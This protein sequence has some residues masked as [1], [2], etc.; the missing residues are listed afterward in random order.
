[1]K[2][3]ILST[4]TTLLLSSF[5]MMAFAQSTFTVSLLDSEGIATLNYSEAKVTFWDSG[6]KTAINNND[7]TFTVNTSSS[8]ETV[9]MIYYG[10]STSANISADYTFNTV[11][12]TFELKGCDDTPLEGGDIIVWSNGYKTLGSTDASGLYSTE[13]LPVSDQF[14]MQYDGQ[15]VEKTQDVGANPTVTFIATK[16][17][18]NWSGGIRYWS[19]G[20]QWFNSPQYMLKDRSFTFFEG[21]PPSP[22]SQVLTTTVPISGCTAGGTLIQLVDETDAPL[23]NFGGAP[24]PNNLKYR[25]RCGGSWANSGTFETDANG[26]AFLTTSCA[27]NNWDGKITVTV[28]QT[29]KEQDVTVNS[30]FQLSKVNVTLN[31]CDPSTPI[32]GG[33][34]DQGGGYWYNHGTTDASGTVS[35]YAFAGNNVKVRMGYNYNSSETRTGVPVEFP[36]TNIDYTTTTLNIRSGGEV[37]IA[38][39]SWFTVTS[40]SEILPGTYDFTFDGGPKTPIEVSGCTFEKTAVTVKLIDSD[41]NGLEGGEAKYNSGGWQSLGTT[42]E[43]GEIF[44]LLDDP[45]KTYAFRMYWEGSYV[46]K[47]QNL[48]TNSVVVFQTV[49][50]QMELHASDGT[51]QLIGEGKVNSGGWKTLGNT[52]TAGKELL[53]KTYAFR[54][55]YEGSYIQK[56]QNIGADPLVVFETVL[57]KMELHASDGTTQLT[58]EG[59]V[60][61]GGWKSMGNTPDAEKELL[62][63]TYAFRIYYEG[64]YIQKNQDIGSDPLVVFETVLATV[65]LLDS[66]DSEL[67]AEAKV[68]SDGW[69]TMGT[70][71][72][73]MELLPKTYAFRVYFEGTYLQKNQNIATDPVVIFRGTSVTLQFT[74]DIQYNSGGWKTFSS[75]MTLLPK[76]YAFRFSAPG[77]PTI[78]KNITIAGSEMEKSIA[79]I[80]LRDSKGDP[81][82]GGEGKYNLSGWQSAG[83]TGSK[84]AVLAIIEGLQ[85]TLA[86]RMYYEDAYVQKNQNI[87]SNSF[88]EFQTVLAQMELYASDQTTQLV[89]EGKVNSGSWKTLGNT[90]TSGKELLPKTYA[91]R[92][93]YEGSYIQKNQDL[94]VDPLVKFETVLVQMELHSSTGAQLTGEGKVNSDGYKSLGLTPT[95]SNNGGM[96]LL[97]KTYAFR[98]Y[99]EGSYIQ[100]NQ[101]VTTD[102]LVIFETVLVQM[103]LH[104]ST[105]ADLEGEGKVNSDGYKSLGLTP[106]LSNDGGMELLPM[107]YA[108]RIYYEDSYIQKNQNVASNSLVIFETVL[109]QME[110]KAQSDGSQLTG[111]GKVNS[112]S[113]KTLGNTPTAGMELLPKTYAFRIYH[114]D[115]YNQ[116]NWNVESDPVVVFIDA[117]KSA[118]IVIPEEFTPD[119][120][121]IL[122][123]NPVQTKLNIQV[124]YPVEEQVNYH[125]MDMTGRV[126]LEDVWKLNKGVNSHEINVDNLLN[127]QYIFIMRS[128]EKVITEKFSVFK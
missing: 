45:A 78:Q 21:T 120:S 103:E 104:S 60:N 39:G 61:S 56:N 62:P 1:M 16:V 82:A 34:V 74:G 19:S 17:E 63:K 121:F 124:T 88:V 3:K 64:S 57:A 29:S 119:F 71:T 43:N 23:A 32:A 12:V 41:G 79:Y 100:K 70:T 84:G 76:T 122:Y 90:P 117:N 50:A 42:D 72:T 13:L 37:K 36:V 40:P 51:T 125:V 9:K 31:S 55:Y 22:G 14:R 87:A 96:E 59:K 66:D 20:Y 123:P 83:T 89:G 5:F 109:V 2:K 68:N 53:P 92:I 4:L 67:A 97:P 8:T 128:T 73:T 15:H 80:V 26:F 102:Q 114:D 48:S 118:T 47:N 86:F 35:F 110:Y 65:K 116:Q 10:A 111:E 81:L 52:P 49:K 11:P 69:K 33:I 94:A 126:V 112:G 27:A 38:N 106:T 99:Y 7:G 28:N 127:G 105:G 101:D 108:F 75:P 91:F 113:W 25:S 58:G 18:L 98:I 115:T 77:Y 24:Q 85:N 44:V 6:D 46:Q 107:T 93:Y 54:I 30:V 95:L